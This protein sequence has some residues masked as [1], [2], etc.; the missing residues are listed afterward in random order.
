M[1]GHALK[2]LPNSTS[3]LRLAFLILEG[4]APLCVLQRAKKKRFDDLDAS[5]DIFRSGY[6]LKFAKLTNITDTE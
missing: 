6:L 2:N 3:R 4:V 5:M 1:L